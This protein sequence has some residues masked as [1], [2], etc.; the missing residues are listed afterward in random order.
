MMLLWLLNAVFVFVII[1][2]LIFHFRRDV[3][4]NPGKKEQDA[5]DI[6]EEKKT[7]NENMENTTADEVL[8]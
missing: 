2:C 3:F 1:L 6:L 4:V 5:H 8:E 7:E